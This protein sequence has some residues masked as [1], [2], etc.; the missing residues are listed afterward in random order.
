MLA[1]RQALQRRGSVGACDPARRLGAVHTAR[2]DAA[3]RTPASGRGG[4]ASKG[5]AECNRM[6]RGLDAGVGS[7]VVLDAHCQHLKPF[8][9][10]PGSF[11]GCTGTGFCFGISAACVAG[12]PGH[13]GTGPA[14]GANVAS[15]PRRLASCPLNS[16]R[17]KHLRRHRG[18][19]HYR[20]QR[21]ACRAS[22]EARAPNRGCSAAAI[23]PDRDVCHAYRACH[24]G[25]AARRAPGGRRGQ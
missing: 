20:G 18:R 24:G 13:S 5:G 4:S 16:Q 17:I 22:A 23:G 15:P 7:C 2:P 19:K 25:C 8:F 9:W 14:L 3:A 1:S 11:M 10:L 12:L 6:V 21:R